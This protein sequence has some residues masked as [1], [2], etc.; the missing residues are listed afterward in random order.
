MTRID[1]LLSLK[2]PDF[3]RGKIQKAMKNGEILV[4]GKKVKSSY[5]LSE[6][7][8]LQVNFLKEKEII[9]RSEKGNLDVLYEDEDFFVVNKPAGMV[10]HP[11]EDGQNMK[12]TLVN[13]ILDKV[14][15]GVG[16]N[17]RP[18]IV[19]RLDKDTSGAIVIA[20]KK[21]SYEALVEKFKN[22]EIKKTYICLVSDF[23][24]HKEGIIDSP[25]S[26]ADTDR[27]KMAVSG[28]EGREAITEYKVIKEYD[29]KKYRSSLLEVNLKTGRTHQ[30]RVHM[31]V[32]GHPVIGDI[33][34]GNRKINQF[35]EEKHGIKR[36]FLH[37]R[38][39]EFELNGKKISVK[40]PLSKDLEDVLDKI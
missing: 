6:E 13:L 23:L 39:L 9:L 26:R 7:D 18:G 30:I 4:N 16:G 5:S 10:V 24:E 14:E 38:D 31:S 8:D 2:Y 17:L 32:L 1:K 34:Y 25:I 29:F 35:F 28:K 37:A 15:E 40:A 36:Q 11:S 22:R 27:K 33:K 12:G 3:S 19:H 21:K 20:K